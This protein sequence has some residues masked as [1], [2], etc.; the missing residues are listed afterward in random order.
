MQDLKVGVTKYYNDAQLKGALLRFYKMGFTYVSHGIISPAGEGTTFFSHNKWGSIYTE[1]RLSAY[2]PCVRYLF[3]TQRNM[4]P[5][6]NMTRDWRKLDVMEERNKVCG[7]RDGVSIYC[8]YPSGLKFIVA[9]GS[10][11]QSHIDSFLLYPQLPELVS[12]L[13][14]LCKI[15]QHAIDILQR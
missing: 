10:E 15:H 4:V 11:S 14:E 8:R 6:R 5:W 2:D 13:R 1:N 12:N 3:N 9:L 7:I